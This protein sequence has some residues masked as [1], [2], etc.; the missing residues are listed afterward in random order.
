MT[1]RNPSSGPPQWTQSSKSC[2]AADRLWKRFFP[3]APRHDHEKTR[4]EWSSYFLDTT[5]APIRYFR[6]GGILV[7]GSEIVSGAMLLGI[8]NSHA[9]LS[10]WLS[11]PQ[12]CP[13]VLLLGRGADW[14]GASSIIYFWS[15]C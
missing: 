5:P 15:G 3:V 10:N 2:L 9:C 12:P 8:R 4:N 1:N 11:K 14:C 13:P 7:N 6:P